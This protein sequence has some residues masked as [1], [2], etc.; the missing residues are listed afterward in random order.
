MNAACPPPACCNAITLQTLQPAPNSA[1]AL[2]WRRP[3]SVSGACLDSHR[4]HPFKT[5]VRAA[6]DTGSAIVCG[7]RRQHWGKTEQAAECFMWLSTG[8]MQLGAIHFQHKLAGSL[9]MRALR[10][11]SPCSVSAW[12]VFALRATDDKDG[13]SSASQYCLS[14]SACS[15][16]VLDTQL[17]ASCSD[18]LLK[19]RFAE[20]PSLI[21]HP[22][23]DIGQHE[24]AQ[25]LGSS[26]SQNLGSDDGGKAQLGSLMSTSS[27]QGKLCSF[28]MAIN[29][30]L[31]KTLS[32]LPL[33]TAQDNIRTS[34]ASQDGSCWTRATSHPLQT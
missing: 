14:G 1:P 18:G 17:A 7:W 19:L 23:G 24:G 27:Q 31:I 16:V 20:V 6:A 11:A 26:G 32:C 2:L 10:L 29:A 12:R 4:L 9:N 30:V 33:R 13:T 28:T 25:T 21:E 22:S 34:G 3:A 8:C 15:P 5:Q